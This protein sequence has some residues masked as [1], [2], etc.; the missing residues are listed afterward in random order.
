MEEIKEMKTEM[1]GF[2]EEI[3]TDN[4][5]F[6]ENL[7]NFVADLKSEIKGD[8]KPESKDDYKEKKMTINT[9]AKEI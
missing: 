2:K 6:N 7:L 8:S 9:T 4:K 5:A 1:N 3:K